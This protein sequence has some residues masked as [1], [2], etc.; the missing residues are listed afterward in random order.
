MQLSRT[1]PNAPRPVLYLQ[2]KMEHE[3]PTQWET[4]YNY[5]NM[6]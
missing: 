5:V 1:Q 6:V 4:I 2:E 3:Q